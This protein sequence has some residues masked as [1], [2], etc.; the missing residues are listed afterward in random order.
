MLDE[1]ALPAPLKGHAYCENGL[2]ESCGPEEN[3]YNHCAE[4]FLFPAQ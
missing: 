3:S 1:Y 2:S 4:K